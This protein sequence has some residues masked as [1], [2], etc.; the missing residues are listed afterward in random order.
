[1]KKLIYTIITF[2]ALGALSTNAQKLIFEEQ[3]DGNALNES[4]WNYELGDGCPNCGWGNNERQLYTKENLEVNNGH[5]IITATKDADK[6]HSA[7]ITTKNKFEF[8]YGTIEVKAK[9]PTGQGIWPAIWMLGSN[10]S[11][12]G[13]PKSGEVD[14]M[15]YVGRTPHEIHTTLHTQDSYGKSVNTKITTVETIEEGFHL[16]KAN[17]TK[18][19]IQFF[20][21][22]AMVYT[23]SPELKD[24]NIWPFD[25]PFY[26][27]LNMAIGGNFGGPDVNDAIFPQQ[28]IVDYVKVYEN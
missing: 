15:E 21:D 13:W 14:I 19:A 3:F 25:Q 5:L 17:W 20:I 16:Y 11:E 7:R 26:V 1:M 22:D 4:I 9:L 2:F 10:I 27:I 23:F 28:F 6:Y 18:D 8:Q 12:V 24:E